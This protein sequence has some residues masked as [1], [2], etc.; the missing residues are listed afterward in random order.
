MVSFKKVKIVFLIRS[1][2]FGG[3]ERQLL[4]LVKGLDKNIFDITI[5]LFYDEGDLKSEFSKISYIK[6]LPLKKSGRWDLLSF[7]FRL[8]RL[9]RQLRPDILYAFLPE[10]NIIG[11]I[12]GRLA[13]VT[14]IVWGIRTSDINVTCYDWTYGKVI[15]LGA[16]L[17]RFPDALVFNS[18]SGL[19]YHKRIGYTNKQMHVI[20]NGIDTVNFRP[21]RELGM[22]IREKWNVNNS[23]ILIGHVGRFDPMK[24]HSTF[25]RAAA[26]L[27]KE[28][29]NV[30]FVC[31][32]DGNVTYKTE[33]YRLA[34]GLGL[35]N[36]VIWA[37][38]KMDMR[39]VYNALDIST[40]SSAYGE[41]FPNVIGEAMA[42][43]VP[44]AV[45]DVGDSARVVGDTGIVIPAGDYE[46]LSMSWQK[47]IERMQ[48]DCQSVNESMRDRIEHMYSHKILVRETSKLLL[49]LL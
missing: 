44:C 49:S 15:R 13:G 18:F 22:R 45:T 30:L 31:V 16:W 29:D 48:K 4:E 43:G 23:T 11:L 41:G 6:I 32:G 20:P 5:A 39:G 26:I 46:A 10:P 47:M 21:D 42:C 19:E 38:K 12:T 8:T 36:R 28:M 7:G 40:L 33:I 27:A 1:L 14:R 25:L 24:D 2:H 17:S 34:D 35:E 3:T 37:G 9:L